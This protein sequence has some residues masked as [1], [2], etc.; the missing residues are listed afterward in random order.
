MEI[1]YI[2]EQ[3]LESKILPSYE[4]NIIYFHFKEDFLQ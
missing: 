3:S 2:K 4:I 1:V